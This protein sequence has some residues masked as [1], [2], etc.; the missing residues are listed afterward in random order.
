MNRKFLEI[1]AIF[2]KEADKHIDFYDSV[3]KVIEFKKT[4]LYDNIEKQVNKS[5]IGST[6]NNFTD[7]NKWGA[8]TRKR[9]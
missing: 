3:T 6:N 7:Q 5:K 9:T 1:K 2:S 8:E 4:K